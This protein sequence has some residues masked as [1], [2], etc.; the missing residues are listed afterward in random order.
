MSATDE[1][2][3]TSREK[4]MRLVET[5]GLELEPAEQDDLEELYT[6]YQEGLGQIRALLDSARPPLVPRPGPARSRRGELPAPDSQI[7]RDAD[8]SSRNP[9]DAMRVAARLQDTLRSD[10]P[11]L[12]A[13]LNLCPL[14]ETLVD[15]PLAG[16]LF[17]VKDNIEVGGAPLT[18][19]STGSPEM[20]ET[21][22]PV[23]AALRRAG[24]LCVAKTNLGQFACSVNTSHFGE[25]CNPWDLATNPGGS[26]S[27]SAAA[28][29][30]GYVDFSI[31]TDAGGSVR[32][33]ASL[34]GIVGFRPTGG[35]LDLRGVGG[36]PWS[37]D[38]FGFMTRSVA[39]VQHVMGTLDWHVEPAATDTP[40]RLGVLLDESFGKMAANVRSVYEGAVTALRDAGY[41]LS[42]ISLP[43]FEL[44]PFV[45]ALIAY[46]EVGAQHRDRIRSEPEAFHPDIR[47]LIRFGQLLTAGEYADA[48]RAQFVI[49][50]RYRAVVDEFDG[51][52]TP[53]MPTTAPRRGE[54]PFVPGDD[55]LSALFTFMRF[56]CLFN[57]TGHP[58]ITLHAGLADDGLPVGIQLIGTHGRDLDL[59]ELARGVEDTLGAAPTPPYH[60][61]LADFGRFRGATS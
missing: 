20:P 22:A 17:A 24:A 11:P 40:M 55:P 47:R 49:R 12:N 30:S 58:S 29:A 43:G 21:D 1:T 41:A 14:P 53:T 9:A 39:D 10:P 7:A 2:T 35:T 61:D 48:V 32:I 50:E 3:S 25:V 60:V 36:T 37:V 44:A 16:V 34:C 23:V 28:V 51:V 42:E 18:Y 54:D 8:W 26:S 4:F 52:V 31:G 5:C 46:S 19:G 33:P 6:F 38:N 56:T 15:G 13:F 45:I 57:I 27:G 59:L